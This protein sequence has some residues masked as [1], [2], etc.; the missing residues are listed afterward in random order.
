MK[1]STKLLIGSSLAFLA[2]SFCLNVVFLG[3]AMAPS[4]HAGRIRL[5]GRSELGLLEHVFRGIQ[6]HYVDA[7]KAKDREALLH[8]GVEGMIRALDDPYSRFMPP[9]AFTEMRTES[10]GEFGGLGIVI[11][12][13]EGRVT[14]I[15][16]MADTPAYRKGVQA[17]DIVV[18]VDD[19]PIEGM[20]LSEVVDILRG[21]VGTKVK[22]TLFRPSVRKLIPVEIVRAKIPLPSV[23]SAYFEGDIGYAYAPGFTNRTAQDLEEAIEGFEARGMKGFVL[24]LRSNPGGLLDAAVAVSK[25]FLAK[26]KIV[27]VRD[28][29]GQENTFTSFRARF[30]PWPLVVL[31]NEGSASASEIVAGAVKDNG[32]GLLLGAKTFGKGSVQTVVTLRDGS[33]MAL[34]TAYYYT[35]SGALIHKKGIP[36]DIPVSAKPLSTDEI[37]EL[38]NLR[39]RLFSEPSLEERD[40]MDPDQVYAELSQLDPQLREAVEV[41]RGSLALSQ[42]AGDG[43]PGR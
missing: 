42:L 17:G 27:S 30:R 8:G 43:R 23:R 38:R 7:D 2:I 32:R 15:S 3:K 13:R 9:E 6:Q 24:D 18:R 35:P 26:G 36:P 12:M 14:V 33:A 4:A 28:R 20:G 34:T 25:L 29:Q 10:S 5:Q 39:A 40:A 31:I 16:P 22:V 41:V 37:L 19:E 1:R 11:G 21:K